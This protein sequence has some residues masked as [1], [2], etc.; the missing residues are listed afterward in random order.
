MLMIKSLAARGQR[1]YSLVGDRVSRMTCWRSSPR[2]I[3]PIGSLRG[4]KAAHTPPA[5]AQEAEQR[6]QKRGGA[7]VQAPRR[8][9]VR[10][11]RHEQA[12][13]EA[14]DLDE[15]RFQDDGMPAQMH[16]PHPAGLV[17]MRV[18]PFQP[19]APAAAATVSRAPRGPLG[20]VVPDTGTLHVD[21]FILTP[22]PDL[23]PV[24][25]FR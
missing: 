8:A 7:A 24:P 20:C 11:V 13:V 3:R 21:L 1:G 14:A 16:A 19:F 2:R 4:P 22:E 15:R 12:Q 23:Q 18:G 6:A 17:E 9:H 25:G 5:A 10:Q